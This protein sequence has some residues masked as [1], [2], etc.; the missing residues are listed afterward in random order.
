MAKA[1]KALG[2]LTKEKCNL[3]IYQLG[4]SKATPLLNIL[5]LKLCAK[6]HDQKKQITEV[7][8]TYT[9]G[10]ICIHTL[11]ENIANGGIFKSKKQ[12]FKNEE[13]YYNLRHVSIV[14]FA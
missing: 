7:C 12:K 4:S 2:T 9:N 6:F 11:M 13:C 14:L 1:K 10:N 5:K 8:C 3:L